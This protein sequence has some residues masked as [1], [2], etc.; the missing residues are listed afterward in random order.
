MYTRYGGETITIVGDNAHAPG[1]E[2]IGPMRRRRIDVKT[3]QIFLETQLM[4][5]K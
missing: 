5:M 3:S 1:P 2:I 4:Y